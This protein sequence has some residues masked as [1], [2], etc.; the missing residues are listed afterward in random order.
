MV[1][2]NGRKMSKLEKSRLLANHRR[3]KYLKKLKKLKQEGST[4]M[5][6]GAPLLGKA[7]SFLTRSFVAWQGKKRKPSSFPLLAKSKC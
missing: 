4:W 6:A 3:K 1:T 2:F 5:A 7:R